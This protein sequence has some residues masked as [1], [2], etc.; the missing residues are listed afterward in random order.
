M[1]G[2][3]E[4]GMGMCKGIFNTIYRYYI[5]VIYLLSSS[6]KRASE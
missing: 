3:H 5:D 4:G 1:F 2:F 6:G